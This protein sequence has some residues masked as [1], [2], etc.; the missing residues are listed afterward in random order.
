MVRLTTVHCQLPEGISV[1]PKGKKYA[2]EE[3]DATEGMTFSVAYNATSNKYTITIYDGEFDES[4]GN[5]IITLPLE[6]TSGG[7]ATVSNISFGDPDA[8]NICR[9]A[10]FTIAIPSVTPPMPTGSVDLKGEVNDGSL[11]FT[12]ENK[13]GKTIANCNF[14]LQLPE[15]VT[16]KPKG[17]KYAYEEGD[18][19]EGMTFSV[20]YNATSNKYTITVYDGEFDESAGNTRA[21]L[22]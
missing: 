7:E 18:A 6:G 11:V 2:Y 22:N 3:G 12:F 1:K 10:N 13:S 9:P 8:Q 21:V 19:T 20:A 16:L 5:T 4:A 15:G 17:K 14:Q